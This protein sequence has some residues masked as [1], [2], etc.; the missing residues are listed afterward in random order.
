MRKTGF[1]L[2][3]IFFCAALCACAAE[4]RIP[5]SELLLRFNKCSDEK[6]DIENAFFCSGEW[7][8]YIPCEDNGELLLS[9][10]ENAFHEL[11][12]IQLTLK[13]G[14]TESSAEKFRE[15]G[16]RLAE[17][18]SQDERTLPALEAASFFDKTVQFSN[19]SAEADAGRY[20]FT[21]F[22]CEKGL[23]LISVYK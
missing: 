13:G 12:C 19:F 7:L 23:S 1:F 6:L 18:F 4:K 17:A 14:E 21:F 16:K 3:I 10:R 8:L 22:S 9:A 5:F 20:A 2:L 11:D 15:F